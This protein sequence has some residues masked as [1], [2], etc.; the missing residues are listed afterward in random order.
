MNAYGLALSLTN[1]FSASRT[2]RVSVS[3]N[4]GTH[5]AC[6]VMVDGLHARLTEGYRIAATQGTEK[7]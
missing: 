7:A 2:V 5:E 6:A 3:D 4:R 1:R